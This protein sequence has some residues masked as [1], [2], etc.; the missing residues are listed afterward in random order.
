MP[1]HKSSS[2]AQ[3]EAVR[4]L[5][6]ALEQCLGATFTAGDSLPMELGVKPDG[7]DSNRKIVVEVY[8]R[9]GELKGAQL[10]KAKTDLLKLIYIKRMLGRSEEHTSELKSLMRITYAVLCLKK[11][12]KTT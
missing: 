6:A 8:A 12:K 2:I 4:H 11:E 1:P 5:L 10:H 9:V 7:I 3:Q